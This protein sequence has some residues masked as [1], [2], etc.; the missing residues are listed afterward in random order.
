MESEILNAL[1]LSVTSCISYLTYLLS[2][3]A[4]EQSTDFQAALVLVLEKSLL[5]KFGCVEK[6][7]MC[8][9]GDDS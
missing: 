6:P 9:S 8:G 2:R 4:A 1:H 3:E 5:G 7:P